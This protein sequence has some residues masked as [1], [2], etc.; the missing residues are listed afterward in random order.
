MTDTDLVLVEPDQPIHRQAIEA[1]N[2][3]APL[4]VTGKLRKAIDAMIWDGLKRDEAAQFAGMSIH[5][6]REALKRPHVKAHWRAE[7]Q[8]LRNSEQPRNI[9]ALA[10]VRDQLDNQ[11]ARVQ[12]V[13]ALEQIGDDQE[14]RNTGTSHSPGVTIRVINVA[15]PVQADAR[16]RVIDHP[17]PTIDHPSQLQDGTGGEK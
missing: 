13:K 8:V 6:L 4:K 11:M 7:L 15:A 17:A 2:R 3:S 10:Q 12:A 1:V 16:Q 14:L 9:H 5:G